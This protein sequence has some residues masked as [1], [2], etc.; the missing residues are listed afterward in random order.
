M[1]AMVINPS[2]YQMEVYFSMVINPLGAGRV[3]LT[4]PNLINIIPVCASA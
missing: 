1:D 2:I 3:Y 4:D